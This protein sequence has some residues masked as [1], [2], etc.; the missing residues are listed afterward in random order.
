MTEAVSRAEDVE[1]IYDVAL[2]GLT[3]ALRADRASILLFDEAGVMRFRAWRGLSDE[4][5]AE[6]DGHSPWAPDTVDA[7]PIVVADAEADENV[8]GLRD[9]LRREGI[10][11]LA[12]VPLLYRG[13]LFGKFMIYY[14]SR[15]TSQTRSCTSRRRSQTRSHSRRSG[16]S[17]RKHSGSLA[18][19][20]R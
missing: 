3:R 8:E 13:Q 5:R 14:P 2:G 19:S 10:A 16:S 17:K 12:F 11:G 15:T 20:W 6:V 9:V 1:G 7:E 18:T 4:Y